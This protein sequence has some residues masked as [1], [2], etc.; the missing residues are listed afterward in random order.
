DRPVSARGAL[1]PI[2]R[3]FGADLVVSGGVVRGRGRGASPVRVLDPGELAAVG[4]EPLLRLTRAQ[5]TELPRQMTLSFA[6]GEDDYRRATV[7][8]RRLSGASGREARAEVAAV[9]RRDQAAALAD[10]WLQ[11]VWAAREAA[12]FALSPRVAGL[13]PGDLV[14]VPTSAGP[15]L[16]RVTR[17]DDGPVRRVEARGAEPAVFAGSAGPPARPSRPTPRFPGRPVGI[18]LDLPAAIGELPALQHLAVAADPWSGPMAVWADGAESPAP[19]AIAALPARVG[20]TLGALPPG[21]LWRWDRAASL[22]VEMATGS[23]VAPG[24]AGALAGA[25]LLALQ[26]P[27]GAW[28]IVA[29]AEAELVGERRWRVSRLLRGLGGSEPL[30]ARTLAPGAALVVLDDALVPLADDLADLGRARSYRIGPAAR[31][32]ADPALVALQATATDLALRPLSPVHPRAVREAAGVRLTWIR[33]TPATVTPGSPSTCRSPRTSRPMRSTS[34]R[35]ARSCAPCRR[36]RRRRSIP[37]TAS[38]PI[39]A[40]R[41]RR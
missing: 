13:E 27:D 41:R 19:H 28:E 2:L 6:D 21:P 22:E 11:D 24:E 9:L 25:G 17:I 32:P 34:S 12:G 33:R 7:T 18:V 39:S 23:L 15:R 20:R 36:R 1:E 14:A 35:G 26:G 5:E 10:A 38:S 29:A 16:H 3:L 31:D 37:P 40:R 4:D 30:A 8:S